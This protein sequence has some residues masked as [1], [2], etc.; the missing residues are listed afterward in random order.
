[1]VLSRLPLYPSMLCYLPD[2]LP[3]KE[4]NRARRVCLC[5]WV[6]VRSSL[7]WLLSLARRCVFLIMVRGRLTR[8]G[9]VSLRLRCGTQ[10]HRAETTREDK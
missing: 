7:F 5:P 1:M 4:V 10:G 2:V 3:P 6:F 9:G 8:L